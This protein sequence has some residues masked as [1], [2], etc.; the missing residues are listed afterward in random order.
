MYLAVVTAWR[1]DGIMRASRCRLTAAAQR[2]SSS[3]VA[4]SWP[5]LTAFGPVKR[6]SSVRISPRY[7]HTHHHRGVEGKT[8]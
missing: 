2:N 5:W 6:C 3:G 4:A 7:L 1:H 8:T